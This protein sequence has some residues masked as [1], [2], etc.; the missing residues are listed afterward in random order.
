MSF[1]RHQKV[2][3]GH[4]MV[5]FEVV[6]LFANFP[7][8]ITLEIILKRMYDNNKISTFITKKEMKELI[9]LC[10]KGLHF[11]FDGKTHV[12]TN[13]VAMGSP[14]G[15]GLLGIFIVELENNL[16]QTL[17]KQYFSKK[18]SISCI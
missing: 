6:S 17:L 1:I 9:L 3:N 14:L 18:S 13:G 16:I 2:P 8:D 5:S 15:P 10:T 7:L 4:K 12:K 11:T